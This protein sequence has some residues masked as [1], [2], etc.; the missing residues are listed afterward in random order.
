MDEALDGMLRSV[1]QI[2]GVGGVRLTTHL[3]CLDEMANG[4]WKA[5]DKELHDKQVSRRT[6][7]F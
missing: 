5:T 4:T 3:A 6:R 2:D 1:K 7:H